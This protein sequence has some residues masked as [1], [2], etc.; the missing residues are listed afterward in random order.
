MPGYNKLLTQQQID[1][2]LDL[3]FSAFIAIDRKDKEI[4]KPLSS[5]SDS[6]V[7][8]Q[9]VNE[10]FVEN[11][12]RCH[13]AFGTGTGPE[14]LDHL[15]RPRN[16]RSEP[17]FKALTDKRIFAAIYNGVPGT[18]MPAFRNHLEGKEIWGLV[19]KVRGFTSKK[20]SE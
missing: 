19:E 12:Q 7:P 9:R 14:Y 3:V 15:P 13:G 20:V 16:L 8:S 5:R 2:L 11:C 6:S 10:L 4:L 1:Q 17:Y 18:A